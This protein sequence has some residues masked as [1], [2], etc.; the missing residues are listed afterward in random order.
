MLDISLL[1]FGAKPKKEG[2]IYLLRVP[3]GLG[4]GVLARQGSS[5]SIILLYLIVGVRRGLQRRFAPS[6]RKQLRSESNV[7]N[8]VPEI[9]I[10]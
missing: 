9:A 1:L 10:P 4:V 3:P 2:E 8:F 6:R 5:C 7:R